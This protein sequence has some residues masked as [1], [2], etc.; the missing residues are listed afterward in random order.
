MQ[1]FNILLVG[2]TGVGKSTL[3]ED[4]VKYMKKEREGYW[5]HLES[6]SIIKKFASEQ[7]LD[8]F[9]QGNLFSDERLVRWRMLNTINNLYYTL[10]S[11]PNIIMDGFPRTDEQLTFLLYAEVPVH[12]A[13]FLDMKFEKVKERIIKR[14]RDRIDTVDVAMNRTTKEKP[15]LIQLWSSAMNI[16]IQGHYLNIQEESRDDICDFVVQKIRDK[17]KDVEI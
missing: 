6:G 12:L 4:L 5:H 7:D 13:I 16:G 8:S 2:P 17:V 9:A 14:K 3:A 1:G 11:K 10:E 15:A